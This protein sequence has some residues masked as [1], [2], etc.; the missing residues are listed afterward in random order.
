MSPAPAAPNLFFPGMTDTFQLDHTPPSPAVHRVAI[1][2]GPCAGKTTALAEVSERLRS[3]GFNVYVV[4]EAAT[5]LFAGG[6]SFANITPAQVL[7]FQTALLRTQ[8]AL[9]DSFI[10]I[11]RASTRPSFILSDRGT[12][13]GR[14]YMS[15]QLWNHMLIENEWDMVQL[16]DARYDLVVHLVTAAD[17]ASDFYTLENN[18]TRTETA[19][20]ACD[21][22]RRTQKAWVG[23]P[24]LRI[25][26]N[27]TGFR[28]KINRADARIS[29]LAGIHLS[30][31]V[32]R[33]FLLNQ[34]NSVHL[35]D[36]IDS[37]PV[38]E[39]F[40]VEQTFLKRVGQ[41]NIQE[42]VRK[43]GKNGTFTFVHKVRKDGS[44][45]KRQ[46]SSREFKSLLPHRDPNR[47]TV[48]INRQC[49][50][51]NG[52]YFVIDTVHNVELPVQL[53]RCHCD[54]EETDSLEI[55][56]WLVVEQEVTGDKDWSMHTLS[57]NTTKIQARNKADIQ[58]EHQRQER[59]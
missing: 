56:K 32:V 39:D 4:P 42:S 45:T 53:L 38:V 58:S 16:R 51:Y 15:D 28:E 27:R 10:A 44:E 40:I 20:E 8:I 24:H 30:R 55:P 36:V 43:R 52:N 12:C 57:E 46:I 13:D 50:L 54:E 23:H 41:R 5:L 14:A 1:T 18:K 9:E 37:M 33:K 19:K 26:D 49:F 48:C 6:A 17:G 47:G 34:E 59:A 7:T 3:R 31:R 35:E 11:A 25:V 29:E 2:G 21:L 22:D